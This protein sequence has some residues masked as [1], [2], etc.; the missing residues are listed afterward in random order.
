MNKVCTFILK[1]WKDPVWSKVIATGIIGIL[2][3]FPIINNILAI[4]DFLIKY[5]KLIVIL[6]EFFVICIFVFKK[7]IKK[8][9]SGSKKADIKWLKKMKIEEANQNQFLL[10]YPLNCTTISPHLTLNTESMLKL[11]YS[12]VIQDLCDHNILKLQL[13]S[14][15]KITSEAYKF[16][17]DKLKKEIVHLNA[18]GKKRLKDIKDQDFTSLIWI[19]IFQDKYDI[20]EKC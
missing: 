3:I 15:Y 17:E 6:I 10:W 2:A 1:F 18:E 9:V 4:K 14:S 16:F 11:G 12:K 19:S 5:W 13:N 8:V 20:E 7:S